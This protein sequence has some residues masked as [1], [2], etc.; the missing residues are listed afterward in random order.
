MQQLE[1]RKQIVEAQ[2]QQYKRMGKGRRL[3]QSRRIYRV[4]Q[5]EDIF[6]VESEST[7]NVYY[8]V[9]FKPDVLQYCTCPDNSLRGGQMKCKH[10]HALEFAIRMG[11]LRDI[12]RLPTEAKV[13]KVVVPVAVTTP[14]SYTEDQYSF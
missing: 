3:A 10:L 13:K 8:F 9:K 2:E 1:T 7:N 4:L 5:T 12:D 14:K 11:T 6:Y